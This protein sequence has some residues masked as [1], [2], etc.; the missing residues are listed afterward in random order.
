[1]NEIK[2][3]MIEIFDPL[4]HDWMN[5][6]VNDDLT[7]HHIVKKENNGK[8]S[9][10]NGALLT[11]R[12]HTYLHYI[13]NIDIDLYDKINDVFKEI[14]AQRKAPNFNQKIR[15]ELLLFEFELLHCNKIVKKKENRGKD[16]YKI[17]TLR[18][19]KSQL[20]VN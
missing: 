14:N 6:L 15:I 5:Y 13:E 12:A 20:G 9:I 3:E 4:K 7:Y 2:R 19:I 17:A 18:R 11:Q 1:M 8:R 10:D 16:R